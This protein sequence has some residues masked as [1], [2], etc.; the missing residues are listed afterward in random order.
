MAKKLNK[1]IAALLLA[2][3]TAFTALFNASLIAFAEETAAAAAPEDN[4]TQIEI[5]RSIKISDRQGWLE[6]ANNC[7]LDSYSVGL[8]AELTG[9]IDLTGAENISV[10]IFCGSFNGN[11]HT[12]NIANTDVKTDKA[13]LFRIAAKDALIQNLNVNGEIVCPEKDDDMQDLPIASE[14]SELNIIKSN[15]DKD[16]AIGILC[17]ENRGKIQDCTAYGSLLG[18]ENLGGI[19]GVNLGDISGC[20]SFAEIQG[21]YEAGG[22]AGINLGSITGCINEGKLNFTPNE[23]ATS[24]GGITGVNENIITDCENKAAIGY[25][26]TGYNVGGIT[27]LNRGFVSK[28][29]NCGGIYGRKDVGGIIGQQE[30]HLRLEYGE[31]M[32][33][34]LD[35]SITDFSSQLNALADSL[36]EAMNNGTEGIDDIVSQINALVKSFSGGIFSIIAPKELLK[37]ISLYI[38]RIRTEIGYIRDRLT[39]NPEL[40]AL[41]NEIEDLLDEIELGN[42]SQ[43][44]GIIAQ[45]TDKL[46]ELY[47]YV[48]D[49]TWLAES[50]KNINENFQHLVTAVM[51]GIQDAGK[52]LTV[53]L[54]DVSSRVSKL[55]KDISA[56]IAQTG[57]DAG[58]VREH[59][60]KAMNAIARLQRSIK[61]FIRGSQK[62]VEDISKDVNAQEKGMVVFCKNSGDVSADYNVGGTVGN[63]S[64]E[65]T[66]D[67]EKSEISALGDMAF[68]NTILFTRATI[69]TCRNSGNIK[70]KY[71][72]T[73]GILGS[74]KSGALVQC[75]NNGNVTAGRNIAGGIAGYF[76]G[77]IQNSHSIGL[78]RGEAYIGGIAGDADNIHGCMAIPVIESN[79]AYTG[80]I[81]G[82]SETLDNLKD[83]L[84]VND[85][86]GGINGISYTGKTQAVSYEEL[87]QR[88]GAIFPK[89]FSRL[90]L[91]FNVQGEPLVQFSVLY[92][93]KI[94]NLPAV[95]QK[96]E[97]Y[98]RWDKFDNTN[99][100]YNQIIDGEWKNLITTISS[101]EETPLFLAEGKFDERA[102]LVV[103]DLLPDTDNLE[104]DGAE[105]ETD[106][107]ERSAIRAFLADFGP[108]EDI[109]ATETQKPSSYKLTVMGGPA[110][111]YTFRYFTEADG[112]LYQLKGE[113]QTELSYTRDGRYIVFE[114]DNGASVLFVPDNKLH[115][116]NWLMIGLIAGGVLILAVVIIIIAVT[117]HKK[118]K[119][120]RASQNEK[121]AESQEKS[122]E[123]KSAEKPAEEKN[124]E[125]PVEK[126]E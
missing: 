73:G 29:A 78:L 22:I 31:N 101:G 79:G 45:L 89:C 27:G 119:K 102:Y 47:D 54:R 81:A 14:L 44:P 112:E 10:P 88:K 85:E 77:V 93:S 52:Q 13:G 48:T 111:K 104:D 7:R 96:N 49:Y 99:I 67:Q 32:L 114:L 3:V 100:R 25:L 16:A 74:G 98:W 17:G 63:M 50:L 64:T 34:V 75:E 40:N 33:E 113:E 106:D 11:G 57:A 103:K 86:L 46:K 1:K 42:I 23:K 69:Y 108:L 126:S 18:C 41:L 59:L 124:A 115:S 82:Y 55:A 5:E 28:C 35:G 66:L 9:D 91:Q 116:I 2:A 21:A 107:P 94:E 62:T 97:K 83:N 24:I 58:G 19:A 6:F 84:F 43:W 56:F 76:R 37:E 80:A 122:A 4:D 51:N 109:L 12:I 72:Y 92:G 117:K 36:M 118:R 71:D 38:S 110:Q 8:Y 90:T 53:L 60:D 68:T 87:E 15:Y 61:Q 39:D 70:S 20:S 120:L 95:D 26:H 105:T 121:S 30:P 125:E 65:L 123:E